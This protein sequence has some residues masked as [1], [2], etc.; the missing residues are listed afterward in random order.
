MNATSSVVNFIVDTKLDDIPEDVRHLGKR[1]IL[2][3]LGVS[4]AGCNDASI[5]ILVAALEGRLGDAHA[6]ILGIRCLLYTSPSPRDQ[7]GYGKP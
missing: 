6:I 2:D 5:Q 7:R 3:T 1:A 4:L